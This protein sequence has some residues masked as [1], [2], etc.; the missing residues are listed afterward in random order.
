MK[1]CSVVLLMC[2][3]FVLNAQ[4]LFSDFFEPKTL[5]VDFELAGDANETNAFLS[6]L[7]EEPHW[8]GRQSRLDSSLRLGDFLMLLQDAETGQLIYEEGFATLFEEWQVTAEAMVFARSFPNSVIMPY[9]KA[10][11]VFSILARRNGVFL[12][13]LMQVPISPQGNTINKATLP[14]LYADTLV[15]NLPPQKALDIVVL[16]EGFMP[17]EQS[18][19]DSL[20]VELYHSLLTSSVFYDNKERLNVYTVFAPSQES[21]VDNPLVD[22]WRNSY[23][24]ASFNTL[25]S[26]RYLMIKDIRKVRSAASLVPYDQIYVIINTDKYGG[27]GIYNYFS[28]CAAYAKSSEAVLIHEFGHSLAA[29]ADEYYYDDNIY[30]DYI[31]LTREPWQ[32]NITTLVDFDKKWKDKLDKRTPIPTPLKESPDYPIGVYEGAA[33]VSKSVYRAC[34]DCRMKT[35]GAEDFCPVCVDAINEVIELLTE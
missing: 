16:A 11:A 15:Q 17:H 3:G 4:I 6:S 13:T 22:D 2:L 32:K 28:T 19:F 12:D 26:D 35:N 20:S 7:I 8:G 9:P 24:N 29:L 27:G 10:T 25:Y 34:V 21:G 23:F 18:A 31:D 1:R 5:R 33:Y 14:P 30:Q